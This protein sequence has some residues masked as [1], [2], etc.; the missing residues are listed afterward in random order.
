MTLGCFLSFGPKIARSIK[1]TDPFPLILGY[2]L[3]FA[4]IC[5][6]KDVLNLMIYTLYNFHMHISL[7]INVYLH[8]VGRTI[9]SLKQTHWGQDYCQL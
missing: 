1:S 9:K 2:F 8:D 6:D 3:V 7:N 5:T 4:E